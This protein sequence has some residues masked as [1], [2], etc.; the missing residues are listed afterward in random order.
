[1][2]QKGTEKHHLGKKSGQQLREGRRPENIE[3]SLFFSRLLPQL[4]IESPCSQRF[5][6]SVS[7]FFFSSLI[8]T[9]FS[10]S[11][12]LFLLPSLSCIDEN[13]A[14]MTVKNEP[15]AAAAAEAAQ[16]VGR[17]RRRRRMQS[18]QSQAEQERRRRDVFLTDMFLTRNN[19]CHLLLFLSLALVPHTHTIKS[20]SVI[21]SFRYYYWYYHCSNYCLAS[22]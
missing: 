9:F 2:D 19:D 17:E 1:M 11:L 13:D 7:V 8:K 22:M 5:P 21:L 4:A 12:L 15:P 14:Q 10:L 20:F 16:P 18:R 3:M 6:L